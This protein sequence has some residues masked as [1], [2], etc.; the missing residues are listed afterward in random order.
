M[1]FETK[2]FIYLV[3]ILLGFFVDSLLRCNV[4]S[5]DRV[6]LWDFVLLAL[7]VQGTI[8]QSLVKVLPARVEHVVDLCLFDFSSVRLLMEKHHFVDQLSHK[9][10]LFRC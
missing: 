8:E 2:F 5:D 7:V 4:L 3:D 9:F 1:D 6:Q 10:L